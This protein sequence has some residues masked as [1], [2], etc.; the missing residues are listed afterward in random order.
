MT[1]DQLTED[2]E[3]EIST[4]MIE[5]RPRCGIGGCKRGTSFRVSVLLYPEAPV[6]AAPTFT[7]RGARVTVG[8]ACRKHRGSWTV[9]SFLNSPAW[10]GSENFRRFRED[11]GG[12]P[13][14][15]LA[16]LEVVRT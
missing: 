5:Q 16:R 1:M 9:A 7:S 4:T 15:R 6:V 10:R 12:D 3:D 13:D 11:F 14:S 2:A 8:R